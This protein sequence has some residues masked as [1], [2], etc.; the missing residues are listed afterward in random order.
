M[1]TLMD[2]LLFAGGC[3]LDE[4]RECM[5]EC[6][7]WFSVVE[8][9]VWRVTGIEGVAGGVGASASDFPEAIA[10]EGEFVAIDFRGLVGDFPALSA[11]C[12]PDV[13]ARA[14]GEGIGRSGVG[15]VEELGFGAG[16]DDRF[17]AGANVGDVT[18][19]PIGVGCVSGFVANLEVW[20]V[21]G[22]DVW[23]GGVGS[24]A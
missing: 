12:V 19:V 20:C 23:C 13:T 6:G 17:S 3:S 7:C 1:A 9:V 24:L 15:G 18:G 2:F 21:H 22:N 8:V 14:E 10:A 16:K 11:R 4:V 5:S